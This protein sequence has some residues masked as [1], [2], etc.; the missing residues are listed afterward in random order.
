MELTNED[1]YWYFDHYS[2][3]KRKNLRIVPMSSMSLFG[4]DLIFIWL[5]MVQM[6]WSLM[7]SST[8]YRSPQIQKR[9]KLQIPTHILLYRIGWVRE[10]PSQSKRCAW[11]YS[12]WMLWT[13][14]LAWHDHHGHRPYSLK[15][16]TINVERSTMTERPLSFR[17]NTLKLMKL[18]S[19][20]Q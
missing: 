16:S 13:L 7:R 6:Q 4:V 11:Y 3:I 10:W 14:N 2:L 5:L 1:L 19:A 15:P 17:G 12:P 18:S 20:T 9:K 8:S